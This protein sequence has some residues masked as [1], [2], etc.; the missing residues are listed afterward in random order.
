MSN[1]IVKYYS[2]VITF[3]VNICALKKLKQL[4][5]E[6]E[7]NFIPSIDYIVLSYLKDLFRSVVD[8]HA[9]IKRFQVKNCFSPGLTNLV[10]W[11]PHHTVCPVM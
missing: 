7:L 11:E 9:P 10:L 2:P 5:T 6:L 3:I 4:W 1:T 8:K